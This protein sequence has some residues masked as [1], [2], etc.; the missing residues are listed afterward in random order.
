MNYSGLING[1]QHYIDMISISSLINGIRFTQLYFSAAHY[2]A[3]V[4]S[5]YHLPSAH[6]AL[7]TW[8]SGYC[9]HNKNTFSL[10]FL[11]AG[12][13]TAHTHYVA[14]FSLRIWSLFQCLNPVMYL[15]TVLYVEIV[16]VTT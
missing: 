1:Q 16:P 8:F 13:P 6:C 2:L 3:D 12:L 15:L 4:H 11:V 5:S 9:L 7:T 10:I 14:P